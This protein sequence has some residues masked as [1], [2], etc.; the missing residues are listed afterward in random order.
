MC[1]IPPP[2]CARSARRWSGSASGKWRVHG[3]GVGGF[4]QPAG[5]LDFGNS[6]TGCRLALGA[7]AGC[8]ITGDV[9]RRCVTAQAADAPHPGPAGKDGRARRRAGRRRPAAADAAGRGRPDPDHLRVAGAVGAAQI[10]GAARR[11]RR[12]RRDHGDRGRGDARSHRAPAETFRRQD[13]QQAAR[14]ARPPHRAAGPARARAGERHGAGRSV[15]GGVPAGRRA[16]RAGLRA[17]PGS[18]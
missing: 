1:S 11:P 13:H 17:D 14:P 6:G 9:R 4:A 16:D 15:L 2:P 5:P 18:R 8:P 7:V 3:V 12:A 10:G